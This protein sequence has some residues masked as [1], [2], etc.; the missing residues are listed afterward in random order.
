[1]ALPL[2]SVNPENP[3]VQLDVT[4][5]EEPAGSLFIEL[6]ADVVPLTAQNFL[7]LVRGTPGYGYAG[8]VIHR[9]LPGF[10]CQGGDIENGDGSGNMSASGEPFP[11]E[12]FAL[13]HSAAGVISMANTGKR[14]TN[15]SQ[16]FITFGTQ[17]HL[18]KQNVAFGQVID[19]WDTMYAIQGCPVLSLHGTPRYPICIA[20]C[21]VLDDPTGILADGKT[22]VVEGSEEAAKADLDFDLVIDKDLAANIYPVAK[23]EAARAADHTCLAAQF[24]TPEIWE[25]YKDLSSSGPAKWSIARAVNS[26]TMYPHSFVGCHA[27]DMESYDEFKDFFYPVIQAYHKGFDI[28]KTKHVTDMDPAKITHALTPEAQSKIISTR[29]RV[30]RN[31]SMFPL[32]PGAGPE[33]RGNICDMMEK[34]YAAID[35]VNDLS[36]EMFRHTTMSDEQRQGLIDDHFLFRGKDAMQAAS[37]YHTY[38]PEGR[39]VFHNKAKSFVNWLNEGGKRCPEPSLTSNSN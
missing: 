23:L 24:C 29:I 38:W 21:K 25:K 36:G 39:G 9:V 18:D 6:K 14:H 26:G 7:D 5:G 13:Q 16:F 34:V 11:D 37:G 2:G 22:Y 10:M 20:G 30:A 19:G 3:V 32:N 8:S 17:A 15:G 31:L 12:N 4:I 33:S 35:P 28:E 27:G 1:M